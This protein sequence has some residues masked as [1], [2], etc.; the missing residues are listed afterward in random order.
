MS[1]HTLG[2]QTVTILLLMSLVLI[3]VCNSQVMS[4]EVIQL[5][6]DLFVDD[7]QDISSNFVVWKKEFG[8][9]IQEDESEIFIYNGNEIIQLTN[10]GIYD[11]EP[12]ISGNRVAWSGYDRN[13]WEIFYFDGTTITQL[14]DNE[15]DDRFPQIDGQNIVWQQGTVPVQ[16]M[17]IGITLRLAIRDH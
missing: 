1:L 6:N 15:V 11:F 9:D 17:K 12:S 7:S 2:R 8:S 16:F 10:P 4:F 14:T 5:T 3:S 13:D